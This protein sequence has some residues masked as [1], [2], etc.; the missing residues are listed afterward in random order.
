MARP[1]FDKLSG[2]ILVLMFEWRRCTP[3]LSAAAVAF[4]PPAPVGL[5]LASMPL[6]HLGYPA[7]ESVMTTR[8]HFLNRSVESSALS[9]L[10]KRYTRRLMRFI[11]LVEALEGHVRVARDAADSG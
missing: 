4:Y 3:R 6:L 10:S 7:H 2:K 11:R 1:E 9:R 8:L 5:F